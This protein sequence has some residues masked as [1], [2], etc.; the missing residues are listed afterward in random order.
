MP[1]ERKKNMIKQAAGCSP[2]TATAPEGSVALPSG[3]FA[4]GIG[5]SAASL[6]HV[7][8]VIWSAGCVLCMARIWVRL[9]CGSFHA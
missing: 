3:Q 8:T 6:P 4:D 1:F 9:R 7:H 5:S 2:V